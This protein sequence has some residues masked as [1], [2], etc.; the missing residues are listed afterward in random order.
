MREMSLVV[1]AFALV[2][3]VATLYA[4][5]KP[6]ALAVSLSQD[7][8]LAAERRQE[9]FTYGMRIAPPWADGGYLLINF[10]EH[11]EYRARSKGIIDYDNEAYR[12]WCSK[13]N[14]PQLFMGPAEA[15][16]VR[17]TVCGTE[18]PIY[19]TAN[20][21]NLWQV[22]PDGQSAKL[23]VESITMPGTH[24]TMTAA[25]HG[26]RI[27]CTMKLDNRTDQE[28]KNLMVL[29]CHQYRHLTGFPQWKGNL[30]RNFAVVDG[31]LVAVA[32]L[33]TPKADSRIKAA[34][35]KGS[36]VEN[37]DWSK[38]QGG[39]TNTRIDL[40]L[41]VVSALEGDRKI[42]VCWWPGERMLANGTIPCIHGDPYLG[43]LAA[44]KS[45]EVHGFILFTE[46][47][48]E[49]V[50]AE[51]LAAHKAAVAKIPEWRP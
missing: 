35:V 29:F 39:L 19:N 49:A 43:D 18:S 21:L 11:F 13:C 36:P 50:I 5:G 38:D 37:S 46:G 33:P 47:T 45:V 30:E 7:I 27:D 31:K 44:G 41:A 20:R 9:F 2:L 26:P 23:D 12:I 42:V 34:V 17:C 16:T 51:S 28:L 22:S 1:L 8:A 40:A 32:D 6:G 10:P 14:G 3:P 4:Q 25:V 48:V 24:V 15:K